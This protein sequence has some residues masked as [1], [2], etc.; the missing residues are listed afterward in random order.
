MNEIPSGIATTD[1]PQLD[2]DDVERAT[3]RL[4]GR[5]HATPV[6]RSDDLDRHSGA[7]L[8]LKAENLQRGG[9]F[10]VRGALLA[11]ERLAAAGTRGVVAQSTGN[12]AIA[13][14]VAARSHDLVAVLV[15]PSDAA[16]AKIRRI[17]EAGGEVVLAGR[18][19]SERVAVAEE[20]RAERGYDV[21]DPYQ[22]PDVVAGQ[23]SATVELFAQVA[24]AGGRLDAVVLPV[25]GGS[26]VAGACLAAQGHAIAVI[27][28]EPAA[29]PALTAALQVGA[30][31]TVPA[32]S[33]IADGL[34]P[35]RIGRLPFDLVRDRVAAVERVTEAQIGAALCQAM[36]GA[37]LLVEPAAATALA[38]AMR[39]PAGRY[40]DIGVLLSGGNVEPA[41]VAALLAASAGQPVRSIA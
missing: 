11:V 33:T 24:A 10:K 25:G 4:A 27:A 38:V 23:G 8:W 19:L 29:V 15:L 30:P 9:S 36:L 6:V 28:A 26:A 39:Q 2:R 32:R 22:D 37:R 20:I 34:R 21:I 1:T 41:L 13:V 18:L 5:V 35:D 40:R 16:P 14:A 3:L 12:H 7:R 17:R 31:V